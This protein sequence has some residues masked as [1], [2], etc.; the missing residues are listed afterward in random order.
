MEQAINATRR[1][2]GQALLLRAQEDLLKLVEQAKEIPDLNGGAVARLVID[3]LHDIA[4]ASGDNVGRRGLRQPID[5][6]YIAGVPVAPPL[7]RGREDIYR[8]I[9][10]LWSGGQ[11]RKPPIILY[12]HR[13]MGKS[14]ILRNLPI[15]LA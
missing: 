10:Q 2:E 6:P 4:A 15:L 12:G 7:F 1:D 9:H 13:R 3:H 14:S 5:N 8:R 11:A